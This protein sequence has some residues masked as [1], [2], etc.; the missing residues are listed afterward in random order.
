[1]QHKL[2]TRHPLLDASGHLIEAGWA[3][4][5]ILDY[6]PDMLD[7][8]GLSLK[9]WEYYL[10]Q[11][12][13]YACGF[14]LLGAGPARMITIQFMD[15]HK[16]RSIS[17]SATYMAAAADENMPGMAFGDMRLQ[18][19][20]AECSYTYQ[21]GVCHIRAQMD[22]FENSVPINAEITLKLP[23]KDM[24]VIVV[25][26]QDPSLF[27]YNCKCCCMPASGYLDFDGHRYSFHMD[28]AMG[29]YDWGRGIWEPV[30]QWYWGSAGGILNGHSLG[31]NIGHGFGDTSSA[32]EN[33][34]FYDGVCHK[35][36]GITFQI[37]G[38]H[39]GDCTLAIPEEN[40]LKP[41]QFVTS[42][43]RLDMEFTPVLDRSSNCDP[44]SEYAVGQHQVFGHFR[45]TAILDDGTR[46]PF[47]R[48]PGFAE[49][50]INQ[51]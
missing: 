36:E 19:G 47:E 32:T 23:K 3:T 24:T 14:T 39:I 31:F 28:D 12:P 17:K 11:G 20:G 16:R 4:A 34:I 30:N 48:L 8:S 15:F 45:G 5:P 18:G 29:T 46:I 49:R 21:D 37:E 10:V 41:W 9:E 44:N 7:R 2:E 13:S 6:N 50:V 40:Y 38:D 25:P 33:M 27:Y 51:W 1:M 43:G 35:I 26:Y 22:D 42:D